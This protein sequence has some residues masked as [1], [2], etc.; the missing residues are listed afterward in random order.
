MNGH[1][2]SGDDLP[3]RSGIREA[4]WRI[5]FRHDT[6]A[7]RRFDEVLL[8]LIGLSVLV[9]MLESI[10]KYSDKYASLFKTIEWGFTILFTF[11]YLVRIWIVRRKKRYIFSFFGIVDLLSI[12]PTYVAFLFANFSGEPEKGIGYLIVIRILRM[13]RMFR[14]FKMVRHVSEANLLVNALMASRSKITV[15]IFSVFALTTILGTLMYLVEGLFY[16]T[17]G[18]S[19]IPESIYWCVVTISTTGYGDVTPVSVFGKAITM[20]IMLTG[21]GIIAVPTGIVSAELNMQMASIKMDKRVCKTCHAEGHDPKASH[22]KMCG[23][24]L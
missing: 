21:Y 3:E 6:P 4:I 5:I 1:S 18:F 16:K 14:V 11:E 17:P 24:L 23:E 9:I 13:L 20:V 15:F 19:N 7:S 22:C 8:V 10:G 2:G 12:L